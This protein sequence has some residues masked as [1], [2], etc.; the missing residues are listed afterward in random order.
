MIVARLRQIALGG[1]TEPRAARKALVAGSPLN[2]KA[3]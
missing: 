2:S 3:E 1:D